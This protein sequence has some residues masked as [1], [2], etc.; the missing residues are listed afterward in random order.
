MMLVLLRVR[1]RAVRGPRVPECILKVWVEQTASLR[2]FSRWS[3]Y[4]YF[5]V[6][7]DITFY[8]VFHVV[9]QVKGPVQGRQPNLM[10]FNSLVLF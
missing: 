8:D 7:V 6:Q 5:E 3:V 2:K 1:G 9:Y 4:F 10:L